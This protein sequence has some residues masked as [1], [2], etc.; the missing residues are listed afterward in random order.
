MCR[1]EVFLSFITAVGKVLD[2]THD[3]ELKKVPGKEFEYDGFRVDG[4]DEVDDDFVIIDQC[5]SQR[6]H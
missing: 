5:I 6:T 4:V 1:F 3:S 2:T